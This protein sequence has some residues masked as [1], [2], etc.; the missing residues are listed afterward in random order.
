MGAEDELSDDFSF[1]LD[2]EDAP[3]NPMEIGWTPGL[4]AGASLRDLDAEIV[5]S[6]YGRFLNAFEERV[7]TSGDGDAS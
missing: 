4:A 2:E 6:A 3:H 7:Y 5:K 1:D